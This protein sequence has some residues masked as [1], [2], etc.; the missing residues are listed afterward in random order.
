M[1]TVDSGILANHSERAM[2]RL[3]KPS[4]LHISLL[5]IVSAIFCACSFKV[6]VRSATPVRYET[7]YPVYFFW[8]FP[9][10]RYTEDELC[11]ETG[12]IGTVEKKYTWGFLV[13]IPT[14]GFIIPEELVIGCTDEARQ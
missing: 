12:R 6:Q 4:L 5:L 11:G 14:L 13:G 2:I 10:Y 8:F 1:S 3:M 7:R 9:Q